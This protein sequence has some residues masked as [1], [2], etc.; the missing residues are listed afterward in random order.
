[1]E[2]TN[3]S[4]PVI[5]VLFT[6]H[7]EV[8]ALDVLNP[9]EVFNQT[10]QNVSDPSS[11]A[12]QCTFAGPSEVVTAAQGCGFK[13]ELSLEEAQKKLREF[14]I[15]VVPGG[16]TAQVLKAK[17]QPLKIIRAFSDLQI[18]DPHKERTLMSIGTGSMFLA[19]QGIL[20]GLSATT[21]PDYFAKL[22][23]LCAQVT[24]RDLSERPD[25][26]E[27]RY[28]VNNLR[29]DL[30]DPDEN[31][32][33]RK[34]SDHR[35]PSNAR[36]GSNAWKESN[37]RRESVLKR[38]AMRL[39][40]LRVITAGGTSCGID[41]SLYLVSAMVSEESA[42]EVTRVMQHNWIKGVVVDGIDV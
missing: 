3:S 35:R 27:E 2:T 40:G 23:N 28:V 7:P 36:K 38:A 30:G 33:I 1:M 9:Y 37:T 32:Y 19:E 22:E 10:L 29:Y 31:P 13:C 4:I 15:V 14:D 11:K 41:A 42:A 16:N 8:D 25:V 6:L 17:S 39:G 5:K 12:F 34:R 26:L 21:H 20:S 24:A 18:K